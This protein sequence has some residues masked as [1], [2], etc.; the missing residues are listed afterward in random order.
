MMER[1]V[2]V[3]EKNQSQIGEIINNLMQT[4]KTGNESSANI[5]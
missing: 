4:G 3:L 5:K 1:Q 2:E